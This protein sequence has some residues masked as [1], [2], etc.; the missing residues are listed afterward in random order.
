MPQIPDYLKKIGMQKVEQSKQ[1]FQQI[2][3]EFAGENVIMGITQS[4]KTKLISDALEKVIEH[5]NNGSL[6]E[7]YKEIE[8][9]EITA[10]M[11]PFLTKTRKHEFK[12]KLIEALSKL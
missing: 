5:G 7:A 3:N 9:V 1:L 10:Q 4:G 6:I 12:N 2:V 11:S 8:K